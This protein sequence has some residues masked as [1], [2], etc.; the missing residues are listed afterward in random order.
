M[1]RNETGDIS[2]PIELNDDKSTNTPKPKIKL[3]ESTKREDCC[4]F[5]PGELTANGKYRGHG[6][7]YLRNDGTKK[8]GRDVNDYEEETKIV[9][10]IREA[11]T[12]EEAIDL[13][14]FGK[15][16]TTGT[17][18][19]PNDP[20]YLFFNELKGHKTELELLEIYYK[21]FETGGTTVKTAWDDATPNTGGRA[22]ITA[23]RDAVKTFLELFLGASYTTSD[24]GDNSK[25]T[26]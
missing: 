24:A 3:F 6:V 8:H 20:N 26:K 21:A 1:F 23:G 12:V 13:A 19:K 22:K 14:F 17:D 5:Q 2:F 10:D 4:G 16:Y 11:N 18:K 7:G 25:K 15:D 9:I